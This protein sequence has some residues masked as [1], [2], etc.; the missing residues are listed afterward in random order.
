MEGLTTNSSNE[1]GDSDSTDP[2][3]QKFQ[4]LRKR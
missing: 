1:N 2:L 4:E 3:T